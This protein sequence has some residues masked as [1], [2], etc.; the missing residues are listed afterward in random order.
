MEV[1]KIK[2]KDYGLEEKN[3]KL[4]E[5]AFTPKII[6][7]EALNEIYKVLI[8]KELTSELSNEAY[9]LR[10]KLVKVRT[11][12][13][14]IHKTQKSFFLASGK[15]VD[16]WKNKETLPVTQMEDKLSEIENHFLLIEQKKIQDLQNNRV[17]ELA[18]YID[19][20]HEKQLSI[21]DSDVWEAYL[22]AKK[23]E[24]ED[25]IDAEK[26]AEAER[27]ELAKKEVERQKA[28]EIENAKLK[29]E[30]EESE[31]KAKIEADKREKLERERIA[32]EKIERE[33]REESDRIQRE[34]YESKLK[35]E[36]EEKD[37]I[38]KELKA[39][40]ESEKKAKEDA[41][42]N[43]QNE[44]NKGDSAKVKDLINDLRVL[45]NKYTFKSVKNKSMYGKVGILID[46]VITFIE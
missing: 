45:K 30:R 40:E 4:I 2:A 29:K 33:K 41:E 21:M 27:I 25:R 7:R 15:F 11:G 13:A 46:K 42:K 39:K 8:K 14:D 31:K 5:E 12:I 19:N 10:K 16:A 28:I 24:Y 22:M 37:K 44:L 20:A 23:K 18:K 9:E 36:R 6:E 38:A 3:V 34:Q 32:K 26:K 1:M 43:I 17:K 35:K